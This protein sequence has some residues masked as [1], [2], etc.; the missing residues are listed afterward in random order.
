[1]K[2]LEGKVALIT[3]AAR[4]IGKAIALKYA[5]EGA[6]IAALQRRLEADGSPVHIDPALLPSAQDP[7]G[8]PAIHADPAS[9][10]G[11]ISLIKQSS[12]MA[13]ILAGKLLFR[14]TRILPRV[15]CA[16]LILAGIAV[17]LLA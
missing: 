11:I 5:A 2:L 10:V 1:M 6:D 8:S 14:E 13:S 17:S 4:G 9:R 7:A 3:G 12:V 15:L 16:L